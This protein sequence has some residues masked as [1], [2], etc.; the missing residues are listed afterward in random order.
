[1]FT[2]FN[3]CLQQSKENLLNP[4]PSFATKGWVPYPGHNLLH[5]DYGWSRSDLHSLIKEASS[6][7]EFVHAF[8]ERPLKYSGALIWVEKTPSNAYSFS[9][10]LDLF[11]DAKV[12]HVTRNP[13]DTV[14]SLVRRGLTPFFAAGMWIYNTA[15]ALK[16]EGS[17]RYLAIRY[18]DFVENPEGEIT[19]LLNFINANVDLSII[20]PLQNEASDTAIQT[21]I[22][23]PNQKISKTSIGS[24]DRLGEST[25]REIITALSL[26]RISDR[27]MNINGFL[28]SNCFEICQKIGYDFEQ[29]VF[30]NCVRKIRADCIK[31]ILRRSLRLYPTGLRNYP[32]KLLRSL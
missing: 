16:V 22:N 25:K 20:E 18:E 27:H 6:L 15:S 5:K 21:W 14:A 30:A 12:I 3:Q 7:S 11:P 17:E 8:F 29:K 13:Y 4:N 28:Y 26:F 1:M 24:F 31:D 9:H 2:T 32:A 23:R 10:F 19:R